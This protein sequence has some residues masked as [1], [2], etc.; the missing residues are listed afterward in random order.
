MVTEHHGP[1]VHLHFDLDGCLIADTIK[2]FSEDW[3]Q[4]AIKDIQKRVGASPEN[5]R[6]A[7]ETGYAKTGCGWSS[8]PAIFGL[9]SNW[10]EFYHGELVPLVLEKAF[11]LSPQP[12]LPQL[13]SQVSQTTRIA[14]LTQ[15]H[16]NYADPLLSLY[17]IR[18]YIE[19][20]RHRAYKRTPVPFQTILAEEGHHEAQHWLIEDSPAN[21]PMAK[22][23]GF[24]TVLVGEK[25]GD[26]DYCFPTV[27]DFLNAYLNGLTPR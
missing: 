24:T 22:R 2:V 20:I 19:I 10:S 27:E 26:A 6:S 16:R 12:K 7:A 23:F 1:A 18:Q 11:L 21:L 13:L 14:V 15:N 4:L 17:G 9:D 3:I 5:I 25:H 8:L